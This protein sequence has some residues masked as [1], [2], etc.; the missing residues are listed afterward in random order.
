VREAIVYGSRARGAHNAESDA[1]IADIINGKPG[2]R[3]AASMDMAGIAFHVMME[4]AVMVQPL[5]L[6]PNALARPETL[7]NPALARRAT[8]VRRAP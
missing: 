3:A 7:N 1:D 8:R 2:D 4:T 5:R 6:W